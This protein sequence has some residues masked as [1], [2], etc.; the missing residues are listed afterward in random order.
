[1]S[2]TIS[3]P[4]KRTIDATDQ[5]LQHCSA[6]TTRANISKPVSNDFIS[7]RT[8]SFYNVS[9]TVVSRHETWHLPLMRSGLKKQIINGVS[10]IFT[11]GMNAIM[12]KIH[13]FT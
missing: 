10:G 13:Y 2:A 8:V 12:G 1:M 7:N 4:R 6:S 3:S 9:Y 5:D 11:P